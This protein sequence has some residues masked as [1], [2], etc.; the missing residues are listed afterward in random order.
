MNLLNIILLFF[1]IGL[2]LVLML[3]LYIMNLPEDI[4]DEGKCY[5]KKS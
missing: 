4:S 5:D 2:S 3:S 1:N